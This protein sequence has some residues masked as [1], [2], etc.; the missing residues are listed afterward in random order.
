MSLDELLS[1]LQAPDLLAP[2]PCVGLSS[3]PAPIAATSAAEV[4]PA[5][6]Q[7]LAVSRLRAAK[8]ITSDNFTK[9]S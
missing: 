3:V 5:K 6:S 1:V 4:P 2:A 9:V 7:Q 8:A